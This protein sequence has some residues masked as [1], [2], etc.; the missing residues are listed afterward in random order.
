KGLEGIEF[1]M[2]WGVKCRRVKSPLLGKHSAYTALAAAAV[3][4]TEGLAW[5]EVICGIERM[6]SVNRIQVRKGINGTAVLDDTY[7]AS[8]AST[9]AALDLLAEMRGR[10]I[11]ILGDMLELGSFEEE[12]HRM[13]GERAASVADHLIVLGSRA[14]TIGHEAARLGLRSVDYSDSSQEVLAKLTAIFAPGDF[15]LVKG[16]R[17]LGMESIVEGLVAD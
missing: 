12:G 4:F 16:S 9:L 13:V 14:V 15:I 8:P 5:D 1:T 10:R 11:A 3:A 17:S 7:N 6:G 2:C